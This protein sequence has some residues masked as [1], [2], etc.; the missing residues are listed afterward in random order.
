MNSHTPSSPDTIV[1]GRT[2]DGLHGLH[3]RPAQE[4]FVIR[5]SRPDTLCGTTFIAKTLISF[6]VGRGTQGDFQLEIRHLA[7]E[8]TATFLVIHNQ[9]GPL[10]AVCL[11][12][13]AA[14]FGRSFGK[15]LADVPYFAVPYR[16]EKNAH[17]LPPLGWP[18]FSLTAAF[19]PRR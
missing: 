5:S 19:L 3:Y 7:A 10:V 15:K 9:R 4:Y 14:D 16:V 18:K 13:H 6:L 17:K 11:T 12:R 2:P 8:T 1:M